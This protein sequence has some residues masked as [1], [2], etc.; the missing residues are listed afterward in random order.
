MKVTLRT[1]A[2]LLSSA[3]MVS[4]SNVNDDPDISQTPIEFGTTVSRAA[5]SDKNGLSSF[6]VWGGYQGVEDLFDGTVVDKNG[7]YTDGTRYWIPGETFN[8]YAVHPAA[9]PQGTTAGVTNVANNGTITVTDFDCSATGADAVDL[10]T[11]T[12]PGIPGDNPPESVNLNFKHELARVKFQA[13]TQGSKVTINSVKI[14]GIAY[15]GDLTYTYSPS[16][17]SNWGYKAESSNTDDIF[18]IK[19]ITIESSIDEKITD[20]MGDMLILPQQLIEDKHQLTISYSYNQEAKVYERNVNLYI[21]DEVTAW[22]AGQ[23]YVYT[24]D[25]RSA[26]L[27]LTVNIKDW[28]SENTEIDWKPTPS[29]P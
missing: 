5:V 9:L 25:L 18:S 22:N 16:E 27:N 19:N 26:S 4:C 11:A 14:N 15:K 12:A 17:N 2:G 8:F 23:S 13:K 28:E 1:I 3:V 24:L 6:S 10:M 29:N 20:I 21:K 7:A